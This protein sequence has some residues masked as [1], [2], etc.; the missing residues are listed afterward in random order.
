MGL[1][2]EE[3]EARPMKNRK[4]RYIVG[5]LI[6]ILVLAGIGAGAGIVVATD[7]DD[8]QPIT[9]TALER[10]SQVALTHT[11]QGTVTETEA[12]DEDGAYEV[13]VTL[14]N[15]RQVDVHLDA[16]FNVIDSQQDGETAENGDVDTDPDSD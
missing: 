16:G 6:A 3:K 1:E 10:A 12:G 15:G 2:S 7:S 11:G 13:E 9:G 14:D 4:R 5:G 8:S